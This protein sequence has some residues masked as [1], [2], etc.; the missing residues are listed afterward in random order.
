MNL[1]YLVILRLIRYKTYNNK[2]VL[3]NN[4]GK[5]EYT[6]LFRLLY[7]VSNI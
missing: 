6:L 2:L 3:V 7:L 4:R 1:R 5:Y